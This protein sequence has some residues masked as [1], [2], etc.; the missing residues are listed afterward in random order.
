MSVKDR[1]KALGWDRAQLALRAGVD[2][3]VCMLV[4]RGEWSEEETLG[5]VHEVLQRAEA[6]ELDVQLPPFTGPTPQ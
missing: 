6:G 4:E 3:A 5:R 1:R 2:K